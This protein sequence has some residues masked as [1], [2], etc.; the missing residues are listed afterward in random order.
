MNPP[1]SVGHPD[2]DETSEEL[3]VRT[4]PH[5]G[6]RHEAIFGRL[7]RLQPGSR[8]VI[9]NDHDPRPLR[10]QLDAAW[11]ELFAWKYL[12]AGPEEWRVAITRRR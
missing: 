8:L 6:G 9:I 1:V 7:N 12:Q 5:G 3:D 4:L 2:N 11:P 10:F